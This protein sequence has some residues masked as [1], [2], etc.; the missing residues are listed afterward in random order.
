[1]IPRNDA[2]PQHSNSYPTPR[3]FSIYH[4]LIFKLQQNLKMKNQL[5]PISNCAPVCV[6]LSGIVIRCSVPHFSSALLSLRKLRYSGFT[7]LNSYILNDKKKV[8]QR[9][10]PPFPKVAHIPSVFLITNS[11]LTPHKMNYIWLYG[12]WFYVGC[13]F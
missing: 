12:N 5:H 4:F 10:G 1:M 11:I 2:K 3:V 13:V 8:M 7:I 6:L 9:R